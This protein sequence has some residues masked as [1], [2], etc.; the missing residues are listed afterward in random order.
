MSLADWDLELDTV[1]RELDAV[2]TARGKTSGT[3]GRAMRAMTARRIKIVQAQLD[4]ERTLDR[5]R[6]LE[7]RELLL[8]AREKALL[9][10]ARLWLASAPKL[11]AERTRI[12]AR[13]LWVRLVRARLAGEGDHRPLSE[14]DA[15]DLVALAVRHANLEKTERYLAETLTRVRARKQSLTERYRVV[16]IALTNKTAGVSLAGRWGKTLSEALQSPQARAIARLMRAALPP[17][18]GG[19]AA[20]D[21]ETAA[22]LAARRVETQT[23]RLLGLCKS[24][25]FRRLADPR[26]DANDKL[27]ERFASGLRRL[28]ELE[29]ESQSGW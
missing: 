13:S 15:D 9:H 26:A 3:R 16:E 10:G 4:S 14:L 6:K 22:R 11:E 2:L 18:R 21:D 23:R 29:A 28:D 7:A 1:A 27:L 20:L 12:A 25:V 8:P 19:T 5:L 24:V 17:G